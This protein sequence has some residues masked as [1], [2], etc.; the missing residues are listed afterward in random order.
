MLSTVVFGE[1]AMKTNSITLFLCGDVMTGRGID[2]VL[3]HPSAP[4]IYE[5]YLKDAR[6]YVALAERANGPIR[7]PV[8]YAY[9]WG[10]A[11]DELT[12]AAPDVR[13]IN[14]ETSIT[15]HDK[16]WVGKGIQYRMHPANVP[17][18]TS[19]KVDCCTLA[20]NHVLDWDYA[21]LKQTL[22]ILE[23]AGLKYAGAG[24]NLQQAASPAILE[25]EGKGRV[26][27]FA[28]GAPSSGVPSSWGATGKRSGVNL[29]PEL[30]EQSIAQ[31]KEQVSAVKQP[32]DVVVASIHWG[33]NWGYHIPSDHRAFAYQ[34]IDTAGVDIIHGHSSHHPMGIE[35]YKGKP[36]LYGCGDFLNDYEGIGGREEYRSDLTLMYFPC[37]D[38]ATGALT[39][40]RLVPMRIR[41]FRLNRVSRADAVWLRDMLNRE[42]RPLGAGVE[43][44]EE[45]RMILKWD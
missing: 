26:L 30:S 22:E 17:C 6:G 11:L 16:F 39:D 31:I 20:N 2:Q 5:S 35:V 24:R 18:I 12:R 44:D 32:G 41:N 42:G 14:L 25:V 36:I 28:Y 38:P 15:T 34:L 19:A 7:K 9:I 45:N 4:R 33:G 37:V 3:P 43:L 13:I 27:V 1:Q 40:F 29:L 23:A 8:D 21:G 10:D